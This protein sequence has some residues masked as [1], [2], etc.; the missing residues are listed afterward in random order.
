MSFRD[1]ID[2]EYGLDK[3]FVRS[4]LKRV[5]E[6]I[7]YKPTQEIECNNTINGIELDCTQKL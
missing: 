5:Q 1:L 2:R 6:S 4:S 7:D 3:S